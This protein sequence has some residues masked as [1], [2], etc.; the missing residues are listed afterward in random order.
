MWREALELYQAQGRD[1]DAERVRRQLDALGPT[2]G[3]GSP[4]P[5]CESRPADPVRDTA[6]GG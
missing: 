3:N 6:D 2:N 5:R 1:E 4:G